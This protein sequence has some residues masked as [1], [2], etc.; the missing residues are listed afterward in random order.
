VRPK[1]EFHFIERVFRVLRAALAGMH[2]A[3]EGCLEQIPGAGK[4][5]PC[6]RSRLDATNRRLDD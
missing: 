5:V 3:R 6:P 1:N 2:P 4:G